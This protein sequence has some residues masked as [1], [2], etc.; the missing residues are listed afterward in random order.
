MSTPID[1]SEVGLEETNG[2]TVQ[3]S[4]VTIDEEGRE[5]IKNEKLAEI[6]KKRIESDESASYVGSSP[7]DG[8]F[9][10]LNWKCTGAT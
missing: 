6:L 1:S 5:V 9:I 8:E 3:P 4:E 10:T 7:G 2:I